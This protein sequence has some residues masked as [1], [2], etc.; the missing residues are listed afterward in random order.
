[1]RNDDHSVLQRF[2]VSTTSS[3]NKRLNVGSMTVKDVHHRKK[4]GTEANP[5]GRNLGR[6]ARRRHGSWIWRWA[7]IHK[8][9]S[10]GTGQQ[11]S[12]RLLSGL[13]MDGSLVASPFC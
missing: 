4:T 6:P 3:I 2:P 5:G 8:F 11:K 12:G 7:G 10:D 9:A 1:M 13:D